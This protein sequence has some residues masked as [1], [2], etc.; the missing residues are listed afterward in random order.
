MRAYI[1]ADL[2]RRYL[3]WK[4][5]KLKHV[6]NITD[7]DD[8]TIRDSRKEGVSLREFTERYTKAFFD[9]L[10]TLNIEKVEAYPKATEH[11]GD[12]VK[13]IEALLKKGVAYKSNDAIYFSIAKFRGYGEMAHLDLE[14]LKAGA[15][16]SQD[17]YD[18]ASARDFA[19][20]KFWEIGRASCRERV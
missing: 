17:E 14:G 11:I 15:R 5:Y 8:K 3:K 18:K 4:G 13:L 19:L 6:M 1:A 16:V 9:D 10:A 7:V 12:M 2:T 20:W